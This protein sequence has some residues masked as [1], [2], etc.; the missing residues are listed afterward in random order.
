V[1][2]LPS[3]LAADPIYKAIAI[4]RYLE[5]EGYYTLKV[6][7]RSTSDPAAPFLFG[8]MRGYCVHFAHS[9]VHLLRSQ[10]IAARV[11]L[12]YAVDAR[13][14]SNSSAV[15]ITGDRAHAW[16][17]IHIE[18]VGWV[19]FDIYPEQSDE[20]PPQSVSQSL[21]SL[22]GE[23]ARN[24]VRR[25]IKR[26][27]P[28]PWATVGISALYLLLGL[29]SLGYLVGFWRVVRVR[30]ADPEEQGRLAFIQALDR[31][32]SAGFTRGEGE[33]RE[34][35]AR[36]LEERAPGLIELTDAHLSWALGAP[37]R[38]STRGQLV[39]ERAAIVRSSFARRNSLR[40]LLALLNPFGWL[41]SR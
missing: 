40:W 6:K 27:P 7:H 20:P 9:A 2:E 23:I 39:R 22:F 36:R 10:G 28:F 13:T 21:E 32:A 38:R 17:E 15:L 26:G 18:G 8:D 35:F 19:T 11:A 25:G 12:G 30:F 31:L 5:R 3:Y 41:Y 37:Q 16:P 33:S 24:Q 29:I 14:R 34:V 4:K 1:R